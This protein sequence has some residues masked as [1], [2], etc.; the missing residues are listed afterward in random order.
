MTNPLKSPRVQRAT[1]CT[2]ALLD[3]YGCYRTAE[4]TLAGRYADAAIYC[5]ATIGFA[6]AVARDWKRISR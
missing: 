2:I 3:L 1:L 4:L 6:Y 5:A